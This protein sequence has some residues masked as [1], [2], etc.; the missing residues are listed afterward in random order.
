MVGVNVPIPVPMAFQQL[1]RLEALLVRRHGG[2]RH[3]RR[4]LLHA[5]EDS[6]CTLARPDPRWRRIRYA[7]NAVTSVPT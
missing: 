2:T 1:R 6:N 4:A 5:R 7:D 3:G